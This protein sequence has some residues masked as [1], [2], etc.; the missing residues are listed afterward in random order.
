MTWK[1]VTNT[2]P[3]TAA[4]FGGD[5][6]DKIS[7]LFSGVLDVDSVDI[8]SVWKF[9]D[10][11]LEISNP[12]D[13]FQYR[14]R[15]AAIGLDVDLNLPLLLASD[16]VVTENFIQTLLGK[17]LTQPTIADFVNAGHSHLNAAGG[18]TIT[19]AAISDLGVLAALVADNLS[20]FAATTSLQLLGVISDETGSGLLVF[21]NTPTIITPTIASFVN[22]THDHQAAA[23][24]GTLGKAAI[25]ATTVFTDQANIFGD[26]AQTFRDNQ[27]FIQNPATTFEYQIVAA[28]IAGDII[29]NLPLMSATGAFI[30]TNL[31]NQIAD[32]EIAAH[33]STKITITA[34]GQ[35]N[36]SIVYEDE[37]NTYGA[38]LQSF[39]AASMRIPLSAAPTMAVDGDFAIDTTVT[40]FSHGVLKFF[41]GE[42]IGVVAM[43]IAEFSSPT[44]T[45]VVT[46]NAANDEFELAAVSAATLKHT[47]AD[48]T[49][50]EGGS[51]FDIFRTESNRFMTLDPSMDDAFTE[52]VIGTGVIAYGQDKVDT[53]SGGTSGGVG[54]VNNT[55]MNQFA[56][57][58]A[59]Y[60][61]ETPSNSL[62]QA[63]Q[64]LGVLDTG[65]PTTDNHEKF[66]TRIDSAASALNVFTITS[67]GSAATTTDTSSTNNFEQAVVND[68]ATDVIFFN[69]DTQATVATHTTNL[70]GNGAKHFGAG[71]RSKE[72]VAKFSKIELNVL[73]GGRSM[74]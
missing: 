58:N 68:P 37:A 34:K 16:T 26:F 38:F 8:N 60:I 66:G 2:D 46:Y 12:A 25:P 30:V 11:K 71:V 39:A 9:R 70:P 74:A 21:N 5:D 54:W 43:P 4:L 48:D 31:A 35:L 29:L 7:D 20:V 17:T 22:A 69:S 56:G 65:D 67:T 53:G 10:N 64:V 41:D 28:A 15:G 40:D 50:A 32:T 63:Y 18:G 42:E 72:N 55:I 73:L 57:F 51:L 23:G 14:I 13:T 59:F 49:P 61:T 27:L 24:G 52:T 6:M 45:H 62:T 33:T 19:E 44:D 47:H 1:K 36:S 3:G